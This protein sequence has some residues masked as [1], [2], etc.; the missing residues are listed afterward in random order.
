MVAVKNINIVVEMSKTIL[1]KLNTNLLDEDIKHI[2]EAASIIKNDG[3]VAFP[4]ETVYGLGANAFSQVAVK[5]IYVAKGRP[6]DNPLIVHIDNLDK[7]TDICINIPDEAYKLAEVFWP[8]PL[9]IILKKKDLIPFAT[10]GGL[11]TIGIRIPANN[12][13]REL[14]RISEVPIAAPSANISGRPSP[15]TAN[16]VKFDLNNK[17]DMI[18]DSGSCEV[19]IESTIIDLSEKKL[20]ILRPGAITQIMLQNCLNKNI[21]N[22]FYIDNSNKKIAPGMKYRH[23]SPNGETVMFIGDEIEVSQNI[24][25]ICNCSSKKIGILATEQTKHFYGQTKYLVVSLGNRNDNSV[26]NKNIF[27]SLREFDYNNIELIFI[28]GFFETDENL[29]IMNRLKKASS[30]IIKLDK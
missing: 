17:I 9:T 16:H 14:I 6:S 22:S 23:Y 20:T 13:A 12:V 3:L 7:L 28:E 1:K 10:S 11:D 24:L 27:S 25:N 15:T 2:N 30:R 8:G 18:L 26:L 21:E 5:N 29:A 19:G 4:T